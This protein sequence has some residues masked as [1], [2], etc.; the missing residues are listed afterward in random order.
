V[1]EQAIP[2]QRIVFVCTHDRVTGPR[3]SCGSR[4]GSELRERLKALVKEHGLA[5]RIRVSGSGCMDVC[6]EG[7]NAMVFPGD[8]WICGASPDDAE[9]IFEEIRAG[10]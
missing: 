6:E 3:V 1:N 8:R 5:D 9:R 2:Y 4:G 10:I 7:P